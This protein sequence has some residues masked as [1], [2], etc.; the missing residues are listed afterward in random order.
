MKK[1]CIILPVGCNA[2]YMFALENK[3][4]ITDKP[5]IYLVDIIYLMK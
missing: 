4:E 2:Y 3:A 5:L 1:V